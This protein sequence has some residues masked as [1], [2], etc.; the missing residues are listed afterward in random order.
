MNGWAFLSLTGDLA[1]KVLDKLADNSQQWDFSSCCDK[2]VRIPKKRDIYE[3]KG[4]VELNLKI[5][6]LTKRLDTFN[7]G[8][9]INAVNIV[10]ADSCSI[11][12]SFMH[13]A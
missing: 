8:Q 9:S 3:M 13:S 2:S 11:C 10:T 1:Y 5:D 7:V 4:E 6:A 12:A